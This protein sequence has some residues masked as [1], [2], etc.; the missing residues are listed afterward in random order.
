MLGVGEA[1]D[2]GNGCVL[3]QRLDIGVGER[4]GDD[5]VHHP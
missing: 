1:V 5:P 3:G 4:P 2:D